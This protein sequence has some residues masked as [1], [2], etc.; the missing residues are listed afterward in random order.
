MYRSFAKITKKCCKKIRDQRKN[1]EWQTHQEI[2][3][4]QWISNYQILTTRQN[5]NSKL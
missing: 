1:E 5:V 2:N 3:L 4:E